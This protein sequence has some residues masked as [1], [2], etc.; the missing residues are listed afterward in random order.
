M[1]RQDGEQ[2]KTLGIKKENKEKGKEQRERGRQ[3][4]KGR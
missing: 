3:T 1:R 2:N 4:G